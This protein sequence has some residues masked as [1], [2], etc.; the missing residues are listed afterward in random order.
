MTIHP[1]NRAGA[2][3]SLGLV[4]ALT[5][6]ACSSSGSGSVGSAESGAAAAG[7][8]QDVTSGAA[9]D[10]RAPAVGAPAAVAAAAGAPA[11]KAPAAP[12]V[13]TQ[14]LARSATVRLGVS[15]VAAGASGVRGVAL[16]VGGSV[17]AE[18]I[19]TAG[20]E[21]GGDRGTMTLA[22]PSERL[23]AVLTSWA[24]SAPSPSAPRPART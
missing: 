4:V 21:R 16:G 14:K 18:D 5:L 23:D 24:D 12:P 8:M 19:G 15:D 10:A 2:V 7:S 22:V 13:Q 3:A 1:N 9:K 17:T 6:G 20:G 11:A